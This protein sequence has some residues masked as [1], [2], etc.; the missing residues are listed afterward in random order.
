MKILDLPGINIFPIVVISVGSTTTIYR[1][2]WWETLVKI[3]QNGDGGKM[4]FCGKK[5]FLPL[6][7][8]FPCLILTPPFYNLCVLC[9]T[10]NLQDS[11]VRACFPSTLTE[12]HECRPSH[13]FLKV[14]QGAYWL[15]LLTHFPMS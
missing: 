1:D 14:V 6:S 12:L 2:S 8:S 4:I 5:Y 11:V 10:P 13:Y 3:L 15:A 7:V 9:T